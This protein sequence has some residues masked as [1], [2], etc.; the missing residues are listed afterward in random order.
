MNTEYSNYLPVDLNL[1][2][3]KP[4]G[5]KK[6][7]DIEITNPDL[8][9]ANDNYLFVTFQPAG[10]EFDFNG[11]AIGRTQRVQDLIIGDLTKTHF[12]PK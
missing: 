4:Q 9:V 5:D 6:T 7:I 11:Q 10:E 3:L 1:V 2:T 12:F 8:K